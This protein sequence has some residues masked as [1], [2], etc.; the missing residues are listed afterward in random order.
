MVNSQNLIEQR[1]NSEPLLYQSGRSTSAVRCMTA[2]ATSLSTGTDSHSP[3]T[4]CCLR[5]RVNFCSVASIANRNPYKTSY[6]CLNT[7]R[8]SIVE[9]IAVQSKSGRGGMRGFVSHRV[10]TR[11]CSAHLKQ[12]IDF[13]S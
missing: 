2:T 11:W 4:E 5:A 6:N 1:N 10:E 9:T 3:Q 12:S 8:S 13:V 7:Y